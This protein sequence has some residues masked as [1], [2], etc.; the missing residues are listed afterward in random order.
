MCMPCEDK[1]HGFM[2]R[3]LV[4]ESQMRITA[5]PGDLGLAVHSQPNRPHGEAVVRIK[6]EEGDQQSQLLWVPTWERTKA[7]VSKQR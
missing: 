7:C 5:L 1:Q 4:W 3:L 2:G 6:R